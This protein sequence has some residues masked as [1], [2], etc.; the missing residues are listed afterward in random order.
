M[1]QEVVATGT[2]CKSKLRVTPPSSP[3]RRDFFFAF[4]R[5]LYLFETNIAIFGIILHSRRTFCAKLVIEQFIS[6]GLSNFGILGLLI[7]TY[8]LV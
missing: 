7:F 3:P 8:L 5:P 6:L 2:L 4:G 1:E